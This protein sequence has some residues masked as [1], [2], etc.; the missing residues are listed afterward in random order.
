MVHVDDPI[1]MPRKTTVQRKKSR[2]IGNSSFPQYQ[3][4]TFRDAIINH[5]VYAMFGQMN[6]T[7]MAAALSK[8]EYNR[9][10]LWNKRKQAK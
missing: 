1:L 8:F 7:T 6:Y 10:H 3:Q 4:H 9:K 2:T 5:S